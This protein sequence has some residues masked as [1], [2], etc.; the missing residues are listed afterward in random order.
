MRR[1]VTT[2][3][4]KPSGNCSRS[5]KPRVEKN[6]IWLLLAFLS[7]LTVITLFDGNMEQSVFYQEISRL[8]G[9]LFLAVPVFFAYSFK[10]R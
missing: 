4:Y 8:L 2:D 7:I 1:E 9:G 3:G 5:E 6:E 10:R